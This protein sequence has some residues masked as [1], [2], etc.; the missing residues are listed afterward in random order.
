MNDPY[1]IVKEELLIL[2]ET[3]DSTFDEYKITNDQ[4]KISFLSSELKK[5]ILM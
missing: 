4:S 3:L 5:N 2:I 1:Y